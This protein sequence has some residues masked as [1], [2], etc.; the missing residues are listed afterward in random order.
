V[1][2]QE[3]IR[4][5]TDQQWG[6]QMINVNL[7]T[8]F[9]LARTC[10]REMAPRGTGSIVL[11]G[12]QLAQ[13]VSPGYANY[14]ASKGRVEALVRA[15]AVDFRPAGIRVKALAAGVV[16]APL[17][18]V[19]RPD[20][21]HQVETIAARL[22]LRRIGQPRDMAGPAVFLLSEAGPVPAV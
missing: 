14:C 5:A 20:F 9:R 21:G 15:L 18:Y 12:S 13:V 7:D 16:A 8:S 22:P 4:N 19:D 3:D 1:R 6:A 10:L 11:V 17:G 2:R